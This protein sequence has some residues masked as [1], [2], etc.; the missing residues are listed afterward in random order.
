VL[1]W[2]FALVLSSCA[3]QPNLGQA[4]GT[5]ATANGTPTTPLEHP[6]PSGLSV[7]LDPTEIALRQS[8]ADLVNI[9]Y[10]QPGTILAQGTNEKPVGGYQLKTYRLEE[11]ISPRPMHFALQDNV[12]QLTVGDEVSLQAPTRFQ[13]K[14]IREIS[15]IYRLTI[16]GGPFAETNSEVWPI[17]VGTTYL[18]H[19][20]PVPNEPG[21]RIVLYDLSLLPEGTTLS[22]S[23][24]QLPEKLHFTK[25]S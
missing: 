1:G 10:R 21:V 6:S 17:T 13:G 7:P 5:S 16:T 20:W 22:L 15:T 3:G 4:P 19:G 2:G 14:Q 18:G 11:I 12:R 23:G 9:M 24:I 8:T 25:N